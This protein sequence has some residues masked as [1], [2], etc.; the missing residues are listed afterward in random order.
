MNI[1]IKLTCLIGLVI[2]PILGGH[3]AEGFHDINASHAI[4]VPGHN[5]EHEITADQHA[6]AFESITDETLISM[7]KEGVSTKGMISDE[8]Y[9]RLQDDIQA[10][11]Q[12]IEEST[13]E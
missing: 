5:A 9:N 3:T 6:V 13:M 12:A 7:E 4:E 8:R 11:K 2:A 10:Q 1:L